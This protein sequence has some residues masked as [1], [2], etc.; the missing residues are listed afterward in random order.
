MFKFLKN[1]I[2]GAKKPLP[3]NQLKQHGKPIA[4]EAKESQFSNQIKKT[5]KSWCLHEGKNFSITINCSSEIIAKEAKNALYDYSAYLRNEDL[6]GYLA[7]LIAVNGIECIQINQL[8]DEYA[9]TYRQTYS[10]LKLKYPIDSFN[11]ISDLQSRATT[12]LKIPRSC[13]QLFDFNASNSWIF[14]GEIISK[15]DPQAL[16]FYIKRYNKYGKLWKVDASGSFAK[17]ALR[18]CKTGLAR[19]ARNIPIDVFVRDLPVNLLN[20]ALGKTH[21]RRK[22]A[23]EEMLLEKS[24]YDL[25]DKVCDLDTYYEFYV[26]FDESVL[27]ALNNTWK[28]AE[29]VASILQGTVGAS[30][31]LTDDRWIELL[32]KKSEKGLSSI[33]HKQDIN[34]IN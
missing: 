23:A 27:L 20:S 16:R 11:S 19:K 13:V 3:S 32:S 25:L 29:A 10:E 33:S 7:E 9:D 14:K 2:G 6:Y 17:I 22:N 15:Y 24:P 5:D 26:P 30:M 1:I 12:R 21:G 8:F 18:C 34:V 31:G 4:V 28:W